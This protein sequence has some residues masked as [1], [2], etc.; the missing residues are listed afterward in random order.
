MH[1]LV[2]AALLTGSVFADG[3]KLAVDYGGRVNVLVEELDAKENA[4]G[5]SEAAIQTQVEAAL[6]RCNI[7]IAT[8]VDTSLFSVHLAALSI[9]GG[10]A[11]GLRSSVSKLVKV[12]D[13][14]MVG[15]LGDLPVSAREALAGQLD[16]F[17]NEYLKAKQV[18]NDERK[19]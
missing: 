12:S 4:L 11:A 13:R 10:Y 5:V 17:C 9:K 19:Q 14:V 18:L 2:F 3:M 7:P 6:R 16:D 8:G 15:P 1:A